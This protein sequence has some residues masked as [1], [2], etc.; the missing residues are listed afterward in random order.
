M[1]TPS[2]TTAATPRSSSD[3]NAAAVPTCCPAEL[4]AAWH[5]L[6][7]LAAHQA[8]AELAGAGSDVPG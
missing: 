6:L 7:Q 5:D 1:Q 2:Y 3:S 4:C 8:A